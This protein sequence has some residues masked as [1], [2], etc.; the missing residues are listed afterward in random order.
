MFRSRRVIALIPAMNEEDAIAKVVSELLRLG[1][2]LSSK[3][4][5]YRQM[6]WI[7]QVIVCDNA[8]ADQTAVRAKRAGAMVIKQAIPGYGAACLT[9]I[10]AIP[11][12]FHARDIVLFVD[13]DDSCFV[14][15]AERLLKGICSGDDLAIGSRPLGNM[16]RKAL[17]I[18]QRAGNRVAGFL[19]FLF[20]RKKITDLGPFR[21]IT[22]GSLNALSMSDQAFG[23][24]V[25]MQIKAIQLNM[26]I[27]EYPVD[28]K[29]RIG[30]SK[31][32]GT[33][34]GVYGA[35]TGILG[36]IF[37]LRLRQKYFIEM[38][39]RSDIRP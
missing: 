9:A 35:S 31:I 3:S 12:T 16:E 13:G 21:A 38:S 1:A 32:S 22:L 29:V 11:K 24:T 20:W 4:R 23:W 18:P 37:S 26:A 19:I 6:R 17:T 10:S 2:S 39:H 15:Q 36:K 34:R 25:E 14:D 8:S 28:S 27:G 30:Q 7:D 5:L 33:L